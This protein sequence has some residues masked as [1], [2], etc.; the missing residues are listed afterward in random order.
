M[1]TTHPHAKS[2]V[3][4]TFEIKFDL[5]VRGKNA[6]DET[7]TA[8][9]TKAE[10]IV[11]ATCM[12]GKHL[13]TYFP[14]GYV[15]FI[16]FDMYDVAVKI[17]PSKNLDELEATSIDFHIAYL[18]EQFTMDQLRMRVIFSV[19]SAIVLIMFASK[20]LCKIKPED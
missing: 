12:E 7:W 11:E 3:G 13:C 17:H 5:Y 18:D 1:S 4:K 15:P 14:V 6:D 16:N 9:T 8:H 2:V 19:I 20:T 10:H